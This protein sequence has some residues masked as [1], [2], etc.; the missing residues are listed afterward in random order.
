MAALIVALVAVAGLLLS[1]NS[2]SFLLRKGKIQGMKSIAAYFPFGFSETVDPRK[3]STVGE[4]VLAEHIFAFHSTQ[5]RRNGFSAVISDINFD[6]SKNT[7]HITPRQNPIKSN[8]IEMTPKEICEG[9]IESFSGT[10]HAEYNSLVRTIECSGSTTIVKLE[11]IPVNMQALFSLPDFSVFDKSEV[12]ISSINNSPTTGP[13]SIKT[14]SSSKVELSRNF[15]YPKNLISNE[16]DEVSLNYY[17]PAEVA[18]FIKN[19]DPEKQHLIYFFGSSLV[20]S[21]L[22][23]LSTR[24]YRIEEFPSEWLGHIGFQP[25][26]GERDRKLIGSAIDTIRMQIE[27]SSPLGQPAYSVPPSDRPYG[28]KKAAYYQATKTLLDINSGEKLSRP[29]VLGVMEF[30]HQLPF[31]KTTTSGLKEIFGKDIEIRVFKK[32]EYDQLFAAPVDMYLSLQG[33]SAAD[34]AHHL[35]FF[36]KNDPVFAEA[37]THDDISNLATSE[38]AETFT[39]K[40]L[41]LEMKL[42]EKR[43]IIPIVHFPGVVVSNPR[44]E[45]DDGLAGS[46][47]IRTWTYRIR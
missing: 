41:L 34:P 39:E 3:I 12:P 17:P 36:L 47:G 10:H 31:F 28:I 44:L 13:Y 21:S 35:T 32:A 1:T 20:Q 24:G 25:A 27:S 43:V 6:Y 18:D 42:L 8:G 11:K 30:L 7:I 37:I 46:W 33:I 19:A 15:F 26:L 45:R 2:D 16:I 23:S 5:G 38:N 9:I 29:V 4:Q 14:F 40:A 22:D